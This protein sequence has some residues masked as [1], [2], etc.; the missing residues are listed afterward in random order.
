MGP[1]EKLLHSKG[2]HK[3][4]EKTTLRMGENICK[5][6][7][8]QRINLPCFLMK[9]F[10]RTL[11]TPAGVNMCG[12]FCPR[13]P[14]SQFLWGIALSAEPILTS[15]HGPHLHG[16][17]QATS[18]WQV[19][20]SYRRGRT[21]SQFSFNAKT[22]GWDFS[23]ELGR[24]PWKNE[25]QPTA[26]GKRVGGCGRILL[27]IHNTRSIV[28]KHGERESKRMLEQAWFLC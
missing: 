4:D 24:D 13:L 12:D 15:P 9:L 18:I 26:G 23:F 2:N 5:W 6:S 28:S 8:W 11:R 10:L 14:L 20:L 27:C 3:Q 25:S 21:L 17:K 1:N 16:R 7:N 22:V 19:C